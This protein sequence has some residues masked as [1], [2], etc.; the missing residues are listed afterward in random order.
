MINKQTAKELRV[1]W[2]KQHVFWLYTKWYASELVQ[3][4]VNEPELKNSTS[5]VRHVP[6]KGH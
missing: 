4:Q 3:N 5:P 2:V 1:T 6:V